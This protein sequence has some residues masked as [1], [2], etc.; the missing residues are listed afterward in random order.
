MGILRENKYT[1]LITTRSVLLRMSNIPGNSSKKN[2]N[3][4][5]VFSNF[6]PKSCQCGNIY[7]SWTVDRWQYGAC[8]LHAGYLM[9]QT[10]LSECV[11]IIALLLQ[12]WLHKCTSVLCDM[13][14]AWILKTKST[15][16]E[17]GIKYFVIRH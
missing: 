1:F 17:M 2:Q 12:Q 6:F 4:H 5:Y 7:Y 8:A 13:Y 9:L 10:Q 15:E 14:I 16:R 3:T 11:L